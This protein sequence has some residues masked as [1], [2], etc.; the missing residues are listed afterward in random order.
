MIDRVVKILSGFPKPEIDTYGQ[1][2]EQLLVVEDEWY[3]S[4]HESGKGI[5]VASQLDIS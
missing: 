3:W 5:T 4:Q 1:D 2:P